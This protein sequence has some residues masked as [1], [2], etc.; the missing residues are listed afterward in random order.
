VT[1]ERARPL[2][3][4]IVRVFVGGVAAAVA[5]RYIDAGFATIAELHA[6]MSFQEV[7]SDVSRLN[8][9][10][11]REA[12]T[13]SWHTYQ[14]VRL[15]LQMSAASCGLFDITTA[16]RLVDD[17]Q[18]PRPVDAPA[19]HPAA[20]W[21]DI[22]LI[23]P[24]RIRFHRPLWIDLS[25]I[26]KGYA[27]DRAIERMANANDDESLIARVNAGGDLRVHGPWRDRALL[28]V[29][30]HPPE[31]LPVIE[32]ADGSLASSGAAPASLQP[33]QSAA[34]GSHL[35]GRTRERVDS[36]QFVSVVAPLCA[37]ADALTK[38]VLADA[39][40]SIE[41]LNQYRAAAFLFH[42]RD[43]WR[44]LGCSD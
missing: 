41:I 29:P 23:E 36:M 15:A 37:V 22:E 21:R 25:G 19:P 18:L 17:G 8:R 32:I 24:D 35:N 7:G 27:V 28:R 13:V 44:T 3:G 14:V 1:V 40:A 4:T 26:A 2:L 39:S 9:E 38:V 20:S 16:A 11:A 10:A 34:R 31:Q 42:A 33:T 12:V 43:G 6:L 30:H 5:H